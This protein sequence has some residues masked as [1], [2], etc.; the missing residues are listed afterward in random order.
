MTES[1]VE[2]LAEK[3]SATL[4]VQAHGEVMEKTG[5]YTLGCSVLSPTAHSSLR[6]ESL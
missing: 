4:V 2:S 3:L 1:G 6:A 5:W